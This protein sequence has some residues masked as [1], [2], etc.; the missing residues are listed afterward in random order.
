M[1]F[2]C[3][4]PI[5]S[6]PMEALASTPT[7]CG[8]IENM[9]HATL[10]RLAYVECVSSCFVTVAPYPGPGNGHS[11]YAAGHETLISGYNVTCTRI[12]NINRVDVV[13]GKSV[14]HHDNQ[15]TRQRTEIQLVYRDRMMTEKDWATGAYGDPGVAQ[16]DGVK[17]D[18]YL[19][20]PG[21]DSL[22]SI[23]YF[24]IL[25]YHELYSPYFALFDLTCTFRDSEWI[26]ANA[27]IL[28]A[29]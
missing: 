28:T 24:I 23:L 25:S 14:S 12:F 21:V 11:I 15:L 10:E 22:H 2:D 1:V 20:D 9:L 4:Q 8:K 7:P 5:M 19:R 17:G 26:C 27:L 18:I 29:G 3:H 6:R 13:V 16:K